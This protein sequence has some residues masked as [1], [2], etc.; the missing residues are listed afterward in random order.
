MQKWFFKLTNRMT[1]DVLVVMVFPTKMSSRLAMRLV[2][3]APCIDGKLFPRV[4]YDGLDE[5]DSVLNVN[6]RD[7]F[8]QSIT[9]FFAVRQMFPT[10]VVESL[11][12]EMVETARAY[13]PRFR[14]PKASPPD[15]RS[16]AV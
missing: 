3:Q 9:A 6:P 7:F 16:F 8:D 1:R 14:R 15:A 4:D 10:L 13:Q 5:F 2:T 12:H 11:K